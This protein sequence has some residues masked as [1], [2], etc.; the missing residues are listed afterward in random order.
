MFRNVVAGVNERPGGRDALALAVK[1]LAKDGN[2]AL[3]HVHRGD[4]G[5]RTVSPEF[6][7]AERTRSRELLDATIS[8][9]GIDV[10]LMS[11]GSSSV[12]RGLHAIVDRHRADLLVV[13]S[14]S[15]SLFGR[16]MIAG[17]AQRRTVRGSCRASRIRR[18]SRRATRNRRRLRRLTRERARAR[19]GTRARE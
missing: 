3:A 10:G 15:R 1:L 6:A 14:R 5:T 13:G 12:G 2:L 8:E 11:T 17:C 9:A 7:A 16:V 19:G 18:A 4:P